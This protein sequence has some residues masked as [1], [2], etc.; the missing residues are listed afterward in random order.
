MKS[1][2]QEPFELKK[3]LRMIHRRKWLI[4]GC[5][6]GALS[7]IIGYNHFSI[8][9]YMANTT[10]VFEEQQGAAASINPFRVSLNQ[11]FI[12]NQ[13]EEIKSLSLLEE[14]VKALPLSI[15]NSFQLPKEPNPAF[16]NEEYIA[17][18]IQKRISV[19]SIPNSEIIKIEVEANS[20]I[21]AKVIA[22]TIA[23][24][25]KKRNLQ[26]RREETINVREII[27]E[28][29]ETF[30]GQLDSAE[31]SLKNFKEQSK[32][33]A[34]EREAEEIFR[35]ITEAEVV[36][37]QTK[38]NLDATTKRLSFI[39]SKLAKE[40]KD[41]VPTITDITSPWAQMLKQQ[42]VELEVQYT[43]LKVQNY[44]DDHPKM[45]KLKEQIEQTKN[46]LKHESLKIAAGENIVD[47][48]S[49][50][51]RYMEES[52]ALEIEIHTY[53]AQER[54]LQK[55]INDYRKNLNTLPNKELRLAQLLRKKEVNEKIYMMLLEKR[56]DAKIAE[57]EKVG[58]IR[59]IDPA[60]INNVPIKPRKVLNLMIA[61]ILGSTIGIG[62]ALLLES[63]D[64]S[65]KTVE[66]AEQIIGLN[67]LGTIPK[68]RSSIKNIEDSEKRNGKKSSEIIS[69][70]ITMHNPKSPESEAFRSLRTNLQFSG[71]DTPLKTIL[72]TS[73]EPSEGKSLII[74]NLSI[75]AAQM[76]LKTLL[77]DLDL[78]KPVLHTLFQTN[79]GPGLIDIIF[80]KENMK[81][82]TNYSTP[83]SDQ[84]NILNDLDIV[85][86][87]ISKRI[88]TSET[89]HLVPMCNQEQISDDLDTTD[90]NQC[91][92]AKTNPERTEQHINSK[93]SH[94]YNRAAFLESAI[95]NTI[96]STNI[97]NLDLLT[98]GTIPPNPSE[99]LAS[100]AVKNLF[101]I[102]KN[103]YDAIFIDTPP[104]NVV[105]D[106]GILSSIVDGSILVVKAGTSSQKDIQ[107][108]KGLLQRAQS[109]IIGI[110]L[111]YVVA[112]DGYSNYHYY[113]FTDNDKMKEVKKRKKKST[114]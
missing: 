105:T 70:L 17:K 50:I 2:Q 90:S 59:I 52:I 7:P 40:R 74:A 35:R 3:M 25:L 62:I 71:I 92:G 80:A 41:L 83:L 36:Y 54:T 24:V 60:K 110:V 87:I 29:L 19:S 16:N 9:I 14:V 85:D 69:E 79:K 15:I 94:M 38:T 49:Q 111:N 61:I 99:I 56:E 72:F 65:V 84:E 11:S 76:G 46:N 33:T 37:N 88:V 6:I 63:L 104:I 44:S 27:E 51:Q 103:Q 91:D 102:L 48:I 68:I 39:Q 75:T 55:V 66:E 109:K 73:S 82:K 32:V 1:N 18:Q 47:P 45:L 58:N 30:K 57:A 107:R 93:D 43:N 77:I 101:I 81:H 97:A 5:L 23:D 26:V 8:P 96:S 95:K 10:I 106:A 108:A 64:D 53:R 13:I 4:L 112:Q 113:Y 31:I 20:P 12:I 114:L 86:I 89:S 78:R 98:C 67:V 100:K 28:Q 22:N 34:I 42:L 21:A